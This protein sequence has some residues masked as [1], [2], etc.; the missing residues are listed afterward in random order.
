VIVGASKDSASAQRNFCTKYGLEF[1]MVSDTSTDTIQAYGAW[2]LKS[3]Y[4]REFYGIQRSTVLIDPDG[5]VR[6]VYPKVKADGHARQ[7]LADL[8]ALKS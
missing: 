7:V 8:D 4:G 5:V 3:Q 6:R 2:Q 1:P